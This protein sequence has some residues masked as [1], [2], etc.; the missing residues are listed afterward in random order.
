MAFYIA[1]SGHQGHDYIRRLLALGYID[2][3]AIGIA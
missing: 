1:T 2:E 3:Q